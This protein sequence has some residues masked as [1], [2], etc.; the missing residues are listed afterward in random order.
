MS[1]LSKFFFEPRIPHIG[2]GF[3]DDGFVVVDMQKKRGS[4]AVAA[5]AYTV[6]PPD[7]INPGFD[8]P[9]ITNPSELA[10]IILQTAEGAGLANRKKWSVTLPQGVA[11][12]VVVGVEGNPSSRKEIDEIVAWKVERALGISMSGLRIAR[13]RLLGSSG[14]Q[15]YVVTVSPET[16]LAEYESVFEGIGWQVGLLLPKLLGEAEWLFGGSTPGDKLL[17]SG[18]P[19]GFA[20][21]I[22]RGGEPLLIRNHDYVP[23][24]ADEIYRVV[25]FYLDRFRS[26]T[27][28]QTSLEQVMVIGDVDRKQAMQAVADATGSTPHLLT[29]SDLGLDLHGEPI[30]FDSIAAASGPAIVAWK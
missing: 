11:R 25:L 1:S 12:T 6:L 5:N 22:V 7:L 3:I 17:I 13:G 27:E 18:H 2:A 4:L 28:L 10:E 9:N 21:M 20:S 8:S 26:G 29:P 30:S 14:G 15:R 19:G 16:V 23:S 24:L